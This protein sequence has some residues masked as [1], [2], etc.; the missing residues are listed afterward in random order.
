M[1]AAKPTSHLIK[2]LKPPPSFRK[3]SIGRASP[4]TN[5]LRHSPH[6]GLARSYA[7]AGDATKSGAAYQDFLTLWKDA[8]P[9]IPV[10]VTAKSEY[11]K[12]K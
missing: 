4:L 7:L 6:L 10:L 12:L 1:F 2:A 8:D 11:A 5:P 3:S 9:D